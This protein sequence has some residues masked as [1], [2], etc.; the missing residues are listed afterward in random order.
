MLAPTMS[1]ANTERAMRMLRMRLA[2]FQP[3]ISDHTRERNSPV[4]R[5]PSARMLGS[6]Q[7]PRCSSALAEQDTAVLLLVCILLA[8]QL[9][10]LTHA[11]L[12][13]DLLQCN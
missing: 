6:A 5:R 8:L 7:P 4:V 3:S 11:T 10:F 13:A 9:I 2:L 12:T 1:T